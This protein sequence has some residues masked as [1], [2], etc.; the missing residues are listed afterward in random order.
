MSTMAQQKGLDG[1]TLLSIQPRFV[2]VPTALQLAASQLVGNLAPNQPSSVVPDY[3]RML[4]PIAEPRLDVN[5]TAK[6][7]LAASPGQIDTIEYCYLQK[8][9]RACISNRQTPGFEVDGIQYKARLDFAAKAIDWRGLQ[10]NA[11]S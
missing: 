7:Y 5:S 9:T 3:I 4:Q 11:G 1:K 10:Q 6:W 2:I 8:A